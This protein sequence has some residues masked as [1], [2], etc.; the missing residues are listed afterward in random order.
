MSLPL[1]QSLATQ[2]CVLRV[3]FSGQNLLLLKNP[4]VNSWYAWVG[5]WYLC[6]VGGEKT[7]ADKHRAFHRLHVWIGVTNCIIQYLA[8][9]SENE[10]K[11]IFACSLFVCL[12]TAPG[13]HWNFYSRNVPEAYCHGSLLLFPRRLEHLWWI[14]CV[15]QFNGTESSRCGRT[16]CAAI[17]PIG[18]PYSSSFWML[19]TWSY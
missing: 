11:Q 4:S 16:F 17:F 7:T 5:Q 2:R 8:W 15:P 18:I 6:C 1:L 12:L 14:Y 19:L 13:F 9:R 10:Q 3:R